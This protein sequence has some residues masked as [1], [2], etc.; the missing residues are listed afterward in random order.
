MDSQ[1]TSLREVA[2][3]ETEGSKLLPLRRGATTSEL[4]REVIELFVRV[5]SLMGLPRS[6]GELY[7]LLFIVPEPLSMDE[8]MRRLDLSKGA[9]SQGLKLLRSFGA[10]RTVYRAGDRRDH[11]VAETE[12]RKLAGGF[13]KEQVQPHL[14]SG[15]ER[16][17]RIQRMLDELPEDERGAVKIRVARLANWRRRGDQILPI[18]MRLIRT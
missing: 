10:V 7:G 3:S 18:L 6:I 9:T 4:E 2:P 11:F 13:L 15:E 8:L 14:R 5:A 12:L 1:S 17:E 16:L